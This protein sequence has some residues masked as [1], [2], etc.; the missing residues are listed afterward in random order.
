MT[1]QTE[2]KYQHTLVM[3]VDDSSIDNFVNKK[4]MQRYEFTTDVIEFS[5]ARSAL[6][7]LLE[8]NNNM[9]EKIPSI[10]FLDLDMPEIDGFEFLEAFNLLSERLKKMINV[11]ILTSSINP[12]DVERCSKYKS[13][14][15]FLHK[16]L[17]KNNLE[18]IEHILSQKKEKLVLN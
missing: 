7:Y 14:L 16:P 18:A 6:K 8:L 15:T 3:L 1:V 12:S 10:L 17:M 11:V 13:V 5:K 2:N 4:I 9:E